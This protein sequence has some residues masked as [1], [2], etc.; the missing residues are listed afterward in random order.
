MDH[1]TVLIGA[2]AS[3]AESQKLARSL[4]A[5][6]PLVE[7]HARLDPGAATKDFDWLC[8]WTP[9]Q[10][11]T[12]ER[13]DRA[14]KTS[15]GWIGSRAARVRRTHRLVVFGAGDRT[16]RAVDIVWPGRKIVDAP[17][18]AAPARPSGPT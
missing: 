14:I 4:D 2:D 13:C 17:A 3:R 9:W 18:E 11:A 6:H 5:L 1:V 12:D 10:K 7:V 15:I 8:L 16:L